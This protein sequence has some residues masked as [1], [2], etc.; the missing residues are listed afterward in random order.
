MQKPQGLAKAAAVMA[1]VAALATMLVVN[2]DPPAIQKVRSSSVSENRV[3]GI[4]VPAT[5]P[6]GGVGPEPV[7]AG[8]AQER[9][10]AVER[11]EALEGRA[12]VHSSRTKP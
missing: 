7:G 8:V 2:V 5:A 11:R 9:G 6:Q 1:V 4:P 3:Q 12:P 10:T